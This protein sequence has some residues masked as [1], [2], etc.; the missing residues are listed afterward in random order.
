MFSAAAFKLEDPDH[1]RDDTGAYVAGVEGALR[2][3]ETLVKSSPDAKL[4]F[5][6][7]LVAKRDG[8]VLADHVTTLAK[9]R[10]KRSNTELL[11]YLAGTGMGL[12]LALLVARWFGGRPVPAGGSRK[13][14]TIARTV[15]L[16]SVA[17]FVIVI[18]VLHLLEPEF[19]PRFRFMS[20]YALGDFGWLMTSAFAALGLV[21]FAVA[22]GLRHTHQSSR[23]ARI[24]FGLLVV[25]AIFIWLA[26]VFKDSI[27]HLLAGVVAF[28]SMLMA[29]SLLSW[30]FRR[31]AEWHNTYGV[32]LL[33]A[34]GM[35]AAFLSMAA[36]VGMPGL[37]QRVFISLFL[38]WLSIVALRSVRMID[39]AA[40]TR[41]HS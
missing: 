39:G 8:G 23:R 32:G 35:L 21:P 6:D 10:C 30:T 12:V 11:L 26:G 19:D 15:A 3:Y 31:A 28:P 2:V 5:L 17:Y 18:V 16:V 1:L 25:A 14:V 9:G 27:Q 33:I 7:D 13:T 36:D 41:A 38:V 4:P 29:V 22:V 34:I 40:G 37:Q 24:G 20:E